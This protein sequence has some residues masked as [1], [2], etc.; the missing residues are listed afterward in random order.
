MAEK[1]N[2]KTVLVG[3]AIK[4]KGRLT[5]AQFDKLYGTA[6]KPKKK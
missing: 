5:K 4:D 1:K 6:K 3:G 2:G